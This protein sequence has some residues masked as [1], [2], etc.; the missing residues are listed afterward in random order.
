MLCSYL[1]IF[2]NPNI[3]SIRYSVEFYYSF[4]HCSV[5]YTWWSEDSA[6]KQTVETE[7]KQL[8]AEVVALKQASEAKAEALQKENMRLAQLMKQCL[9]LSQ[10][11]PPPPHHQSHRLKSA[12]PHLGQWEARTRVTWSALA[13]Q[14]PPAP[15]SRRR[16]PA[17][18]WTLSRWEQSYR[19]VNTGLLLVVMGHVP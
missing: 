3:F 9:Y 2:Q 7:N 5:L 6:E 10:Q 13:N 19:H 4:Q 16:T 17:L 12:S 14:R 8:R 15:R 18:F 11:P 1:I